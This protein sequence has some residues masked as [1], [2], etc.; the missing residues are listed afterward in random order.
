MCVTSLRLF[1]YTCFYYFFCSDVELDE[2]LGDIHG[3]IVGKFKFNKMGRKSTQ[4]ID[5]LIAVGYFVDREID[6]L[7]GL[8]ERV[9][10]YSNLMVTCSDLCAELDVYVSTIVNRIWLRCHLNTVINRPFLTI[11]RAFSRLVLIVWSHLHKWRESTTT[12]NQP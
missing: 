8:Q 9:L 10:E 11:T 7:Q 1:S 4:G 3:L 12:G 6:I 2:H 5:L